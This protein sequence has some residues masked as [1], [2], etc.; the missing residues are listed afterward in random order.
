MTPAVRF[1][2]YRPPRR[3]DGRAV[4][5]PDE[6][7]FTLGAAAIERLVE[8]TDRPRAWEIGRAGAAAPL[9]DELFSGLLGAEIQPGDWAGE[10][11]E[12]GRGTQL[13]RLWV[14]VELREAA[15]S[16]EDRAV[17]VRVDA[18]Y[19]DDRARPFPGTAD[20]PAAVSRLLD[21]VRSLPPEDIKEF[22]E[23]NALITRSGRPDDPGA[24][25]SDEETTA[26]VSEGALLPRARYLEGIP[27]HWRFEGERCGACGRVGFPARGRCRGCGRTDRLAVHRFPYRGH[28]VVATTRIGPGAQPT[29]FDEQVTRSGPYQVVLVDLARGARATLQATDPELGSIAI[30]DRVATV[31]RRTYAMEGEWRYARKAT[32]VVPSPSRPGSA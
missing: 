10:S 28:P 27:S 19:P 6:D 25:P 20:D 8:P 24:A 31:L 12:E 32:P 29:E 4:R 2:L 22:P 9:S 5:S 13:P 30:G 15:A 11:P 14:A 3:P 17:A 26:R 16:R 21:W 23:T 1:A 18:A 7:A